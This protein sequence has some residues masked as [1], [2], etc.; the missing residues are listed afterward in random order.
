M[1]GQSPERNL[2][3]AVLQQAI[4]DLACSNRRIRQSAIAWFYAT[5]KMRVINSFKGIC[6]ELGL[7]PDKTRRA[8]MRRHNLDSQNQNI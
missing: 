5:R 2:W 3:V 8:I 1:I 7:S 6:E 4:E